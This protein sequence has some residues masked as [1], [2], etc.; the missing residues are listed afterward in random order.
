MT[1]EMTSWVLINGKNP[2]VY[3]RHA[4]YATCCY[5]TIYHIR[6]VEGPIKGNTKRKAPVKVRTEHDHHPEKSR[7][8][9]EG[10]WKG[11]G[12]VV[13]YYASHGYVVK[14][15]FSDNEFGSLKD[16]IREEAKAELNLAAPN[17]HVPEVENNIGTIKE[18]LRS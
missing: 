18:R 16:R 7:A 8:G 6:G 10:A 1:F 12:D 9:S 13:I 2:Y 5:R 3:L 4:A 17:E 11:I 14:F 15:I